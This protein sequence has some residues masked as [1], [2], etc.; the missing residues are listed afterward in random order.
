MTDRV[1]SSADSPT[2]LGIVGAGAAGAGAAYALR[3]ADVDVTIVEKSGGVCGRAA[4]RRKN[5]CRYDHGANYV[6]EADERTAALLPELGTEGLVEID[7]PVWTFDAAGEI[8]AGDRESTKWTWTEGITQLAKRLLAATDATVH[9]RTRTAEVARE[10]GKRVDDDA[11]SWTL[12]DTDGDRYGPFD[13]LLLTPPAPQTADLLRA[14]DWDD[15]RLDSLVDA[16]SAV[17]YRTVR[18][19]VFHYPFRDSYPWYG[20][21]NPDKEHAI[22][23]LSR[24]ECKEGHV[25]DGESLLIVQMGPEWSTTHYD[26]PLSDV[27]PGVAD[28][29]ATLLDDDRYADPDWV[30]DQGWRY[31]LPDASLDADAVRL[32]ED[33]GLYVAGDWVAGEG[34]VPRALWNGYDV[35]ER[36]GSDTP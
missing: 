25:P 4:T 14:T 34:R 29:V 28:R 13:A 9:R 19:L 2:R 27:E 33:A 36:I 26:D 7:E 12:T 18:T 6:T 3:D 23:W 1:D 24:E 20:L 32:T 21:V 8:T 30:D 10:E 17:P 5:G 22:G 31:A 35:G 16:V 15:D 11:A